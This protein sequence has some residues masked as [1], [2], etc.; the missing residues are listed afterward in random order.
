MDFNSLFISASDENAHL[1]NMKRENKG[2]SYKDQIADFE[3][4]KELDAKKGKKKEL[5]AKQKE[6]MAGE[7]AKEA[8]IRFQFRDV[9]VICVAID[10]CLL[11]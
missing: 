10:S 5:T 8:V 11:Y 2:Y 1:R 7:I 6:L 9:G 3:L 4:Q